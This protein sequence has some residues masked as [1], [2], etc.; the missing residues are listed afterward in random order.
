MYNATTGE[1]GTAV[2]IRAVAETHTQLIV[3]A[4]TGVN[5]ATLIGLPSNLAQTL[6]LYKNNVLLS[7]DGL[8]AEVV[9]NSQTEWSPAITAGDTLIIAVD[10]TPS[11]T[12][13]FTNAQFIAEGTYATVSSSNSLRVMD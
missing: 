13:T 4:V 8:L 10:G 5:A 6:L 12:Y 3:G 2:V 9:G 11:Q 1:G 7:E